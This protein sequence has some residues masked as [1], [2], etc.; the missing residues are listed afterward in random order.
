M[1]QDELPTTVNE[2]QRVILD[3]H[4]RMEAAQR[5]V[6][7]AQQQATELASTIDTQRDQLEKKD[8][9]IL[10]LLQAL[11][12][13]QR[14]RIDPSQLLLFDIGEL[15]QFIEE[16]TAEDEPTP[17]IFNELPRRKRK[18]GRRLIP[19]GLPREEVIY[20]LPEDR[21][22]CPNDGEPMPFIRYETSEQLEYEA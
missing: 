2:L 18:H 11:R 13:K 6:A 20:E 1:T 10:E 15:E 22:L 4:R 12:G 16:Q 19:D 17:P 7:V 9:Q 21:R 8:R 14:E 5:A 3:T